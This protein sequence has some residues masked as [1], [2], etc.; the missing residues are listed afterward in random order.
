MRCFVLSE[1]LWSTW[2]IDVCVE[3]EA[4]EHMSIV[5]VLSMKLL[6]TWKDNLEVLGISP[7]SFYVDVEN[8]LWNIESFAIVSLGVSYKYMLALVLREELCNC[9]K[10]VNP[11]F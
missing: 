3:R 1:E 10:F 11:Y 7:E 9:T 8:K 4:L 2:V 6:N 5:F